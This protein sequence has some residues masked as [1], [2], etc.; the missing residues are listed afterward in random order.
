MI[1]FSSDNSKIVGIV[2]HKA[3]LTTPNLKTSLS[4][5]L[6]H[7]F[8]DTCLLGIKY[9]SVRD[10]LFVRMLYRD[11]IAILG[12]PSVKAYYKGVLMQKIRSRRNRLAMR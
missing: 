7:H 12:N 11:N 10:A 5:M 8:N 2:Y 1:Y 6:V 4:L 9:E 3:Y